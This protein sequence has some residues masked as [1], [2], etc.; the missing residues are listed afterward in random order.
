LAAQARFGRTRNELFNHAGNLDRLATLAEHGSPRAR[1]KTTFAVFFAWVG[2]VILNS[3]PDRAGGRNMEIGAGR[4]VQRFY[5]E[6]WNKADE[7][8]AREILHAGLRFH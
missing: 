5:H 1:D 7:T 4:L 3:S 2:K 8:V 6:V